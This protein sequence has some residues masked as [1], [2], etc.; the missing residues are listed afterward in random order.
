MVTIECILSFL[1]EVRDTLN[2]DNITDSLKTFA[3]KVSSFSHVWIYGVNIIYVLVA[4]V[5]KSL[6]V[7][8]S[9]SIFL[10][11]LE[12][13]L[14]FLLYFSLELIDFLLAKRFEGLLIQLAKPLL[15]GLKNF[16]LMEAT[17]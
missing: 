14:A 4:D 12:E 9:L 2:T 7:N 13:S 5:T 16:I 3:Q 6:T 8:S 15:R 10:V 1:K 11:S 17:G